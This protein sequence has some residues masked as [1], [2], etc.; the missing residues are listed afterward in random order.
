MKMTLTD[1]IISKSSM[2][3]RSKPRKRIWA[4]NKSQTN[5]K[6]TIKACLGKSYSAIASLNNPKLSSS[7]LLLTSS[8]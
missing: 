3:D 2:R 7:R 6:R 8:P 5:Q 4:L 1:P